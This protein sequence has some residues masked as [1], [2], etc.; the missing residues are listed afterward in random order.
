MLNLKMNKRTTITQ[1]MQNIQLKYLSFVLIVCFALNAFFRK[2][3]TGKNEILDIIL[4][5][6]PNFVAVFVISIVLTD[7]KKVVGIYKYI[8]ILAITS[9]FVFEEY[10]PTFTGN[11]T[12]DLYDILASVLGGLFAIIL[13]L[14]YS[15]IKTKHCINYIKRSLY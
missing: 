2:Y 7:Q 15:S 3:L 1:G 14:F 9:L 6:L 5:S 8:I 11:K 4:G 12:F 10:Y 13:T